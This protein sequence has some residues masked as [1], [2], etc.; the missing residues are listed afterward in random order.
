MPTSISN[1]TAMGKFQ[2]N[3]KPKYRPIGL[4]NMNVKE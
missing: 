2:K 3:I 1:L 4:I